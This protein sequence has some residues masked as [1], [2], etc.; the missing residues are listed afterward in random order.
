[1]MMNADCAIRPGETGPILIVEDDVGYRR[2]L[3]QELEDIGYSALGAASAEEARTLLAAKTFAL[4]ISDLRLPGADGLA[5]LEATRSLVPVPGFIMLTGFGTIDQAVQA[6]KVG[7]DD[8]LTKPVD[9][10]HLQLTTKRVLETRQLRAEVAQYRA[11]LAEQGFHGMYGKSPP[12]LRLFDLIRRV[13]QSD[14]SVLI[15]G[16]SG[17]GKEL[18]ARALHAESARAGGPFVAMNCAG[19]PEAL[20]ESELLGHVAGAFSGARAA[21]RGLFAEAD[22]GTLFLDEIAEMAPS[23]QSKLLRLLQ[24]G[25]VR[26]IGSNEEFPT[27]VRVLAATHRDPV[28]EVREGRLREDLFYRIETFRIRVPPLRERGED[29]AGMLGYFLEYHVATKSLPVRRFSARAWRS[30]LRYPFPGN[31]REMAS[32]VERAVTLASAELIDFDDLPERVRSATESAEVRAGGASDGLI[33]DDDWET[34]AE[35]EAHY[36]RQV[37]DFTGGNKRRAAR[38]LGVG[39]KTLYRKLGE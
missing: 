6:L 12:M 36:I 11:V 23:L 1:M 3:Q 8:F 15:T 31:V 4:V 10:D 38:I 37:L 19:I 29:I 26:P 28:E 25:R 13:A 18:V 34:L 2:L 16:E 5:V 32:L 27:D 17:T 30:L 7:A 24:D 39:R 20:L 35:R 22:G 14:S 9:L 21:R 33:T